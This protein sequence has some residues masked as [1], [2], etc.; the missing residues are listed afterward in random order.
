MTNATQMPTGA[1]KQG[2]R[3]AYSW[4]VL[5]DALRQEYAATKSLRKI[6]EK[7]GVSH[8]VIYRCLKGQEPKDP[9]IRENLGL[10]QIIEIKVHRNEKGRFTSN[11]RDKD[12]DHDRDRR[13]RDEQPTLF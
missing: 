3:K 10:P 2:V 8:G 1:E 12:A 7:Y 13:S 6:A 9:E 11:G 4:K 5:S